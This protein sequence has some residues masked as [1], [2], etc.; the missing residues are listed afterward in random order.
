MNATLTT[1]QITFEDWLARLDSWRVET[2]ELV[3]LWFVNDFGS[4][5][6]LAKHLDISKGTV[7]YHV[8][9]L[10]SIGQLPE[11]E[12]PEWAKTAQPVENST[13]TKTV[14][15]KGNKTGESILSALATDRVMEQTGLNESKLPPGIGAAPIGFDPVALHVV[16]LLNQVHELSGCS[17]PESPAKRWGSVE[18]KEV[19]RLASLVYRL[20]EGGFAYSTRVSGSDD[21]PW[22]DIDP[23]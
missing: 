19:L 4:Q 12:E 6:E 9:A 7:S 10:R 23:L 11:S 13:H 1:D 3:R 22:I 15:S 2:R 5:R 8:K 21:Q 18:W 14:T 17:N 16:S 20:A